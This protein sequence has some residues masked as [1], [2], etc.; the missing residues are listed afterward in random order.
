MDFEFKP[1]WIAV[2]AAAAAVS[3]PPAQSSG[4][5]ADLHG[6]SPRQVKT[7]AFSLA[8]PQD[9]Q[10]EAIGADPSGSAEH[11]R[12]DPLDVERRKSARIRGP[13]TPGFS[14]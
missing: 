13:G 10:I 8:S 1:H 14:I 6:L 9:V 12:L 5:L 7:A 3:I 4:T 11:V 2:L